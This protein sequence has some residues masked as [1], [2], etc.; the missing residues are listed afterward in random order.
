MEQKELSEL[1]EQEL[2]MEKKKLKKRKIINALLIGF[3]AAIIAFA[4]VSW[5]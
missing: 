1:T 2:L 5:T 4:F 3:L